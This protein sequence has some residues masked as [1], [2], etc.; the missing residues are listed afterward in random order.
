MIQELELD[1]INRSGGTQIRAAYDRAT[2]DRYKD[3]HE[4]F[5]ELPPVIVFFDGTDYWLADGFH[6]VQARAET[7]EIP[8][9]EVIR[10]KSEVR[11][12]TQRDA[13]KYALSA[14]VTHGLPRNNDDLR[15]AIVRCLDDAEWSK[16]SN[17]K[18]AAMCGCSESMIRK[19]KGEREQPE[20]VCDDTSHS[21][22]VEQRVKS[23]ELEGAAESTE[24]ALVMVAKELLKPT[25]ID[26][27]DAEIGDVLADKQSKI[28]EPVE[29]IPDCEFKVGDRVLDAEDRAGKVTDVFRQG[30]GWYLN[31]KLDSGYDQKGAAELYQLE[32]KLEDKWAEFYILVKPELMNS[33]ATYTKKSGYQYT[34]L[35]NAIN[36]NL[37]LSKMRSTI[38]SIADKEGGVVK[39][40]I[41]SMEDC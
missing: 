6:R 15:R 35:E 27:E 34:K 3:L 17:I 16:L 7:A 33:V 29:L 4:A 31:I 26:P 10:I 41:I 30:A 37:V 1:Q 32:P 38:Q 14:N 28:V 20:S 2:I 11:T 19:V 23:S 13:I 8:A 9:K 5:V 24:T 12:G 21:A 18:I 39:K 36:D 25:Q 40:M 22:N